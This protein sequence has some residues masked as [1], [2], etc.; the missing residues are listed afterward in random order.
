LGDHGHTL[1]QSGWSGPPDADPPLP[2]DVYWEDAYQRVW[3]EGATVGTNGPPLLP[4]L[5]RGRTVG[6]TSREGNRVWFHCCHRRLIPGSGRDDLE[7]PYG[8]GGPLANCEDPEFLRA[9]DAAFAAWARSEG[10]VAEFIR[11]HPLLENWR[12]CAPDS[13]RVIYNRPTVAIDLR[14]SEETLL[15]RMG[16]S[17]LRAARKAERSGLY[18]RELIPDRWIEPFRE[19][20]EQT[21]RRVQAPTSYYFYSELFHGFLAD[22]LE[23]RMFAV[24]APGPANAPD[25]LAASAILL[26]GREYLHYHLG[27]SDPDLLELR[28]NNLLFR[29]MVLWA[30]RQER[31]RLFNLGGG[32]EA[33]PDNSLLRFKRSVGFG[34]ARYQIGTRV[35]DKA[36][37]ER[38]CALAISRRPELAPLQ[39]RFFQ[40]YRL[41]ESI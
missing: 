8:Y 27:A 19:I 40:L 38:I 31:W 9:A 34:E 28:P 20:Y 11:F 18:F 33:Q 29:D 3:L 35:W 23:M 1:I 13:W 5:L 15:A 24:F 32:N 4:V 17:F 25:R 14:A 16:S 22:M 12:F 21:M 30:A 10:I 41:S 36:E 7:T 2:W 37:Y 26:G 39:G 6:F